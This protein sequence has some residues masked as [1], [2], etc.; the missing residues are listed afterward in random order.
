M[1]KEN[2]KTHLIALVNGRLVLLKSMHKEPGS[3]FLCLT[4]SL[5]Q[6]KASKPFTNLELNS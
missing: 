3:P 6:V 2:T 4:P 5:L 1:I